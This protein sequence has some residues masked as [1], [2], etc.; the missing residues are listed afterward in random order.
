MNA[1]TEKFSLGLFSNCPTKLRLLRDC[2]LQIPQFDLCQKIICFSDAL[3][4]KK[5]WERG[6]L[7][8]TIQSDAQELFLDDWAKTQ[9]L[10]SPIS[11]ESLIS[12][13]IHLF[14]EEWISFKG[15]HL[16]LKEAVLFHSLEG[17]I[18]LSKKEAAL[19]H[20]LMTRSQAASRR[21]L[22]EKVWN[23]SEKIETQTLE[24]HLAKLRQKLII[25]KKLEIVLGPTGYFINHK[26][27][28]T[29]KM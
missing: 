8:A 29:D 20:C 17:R 9:K 28:I 21:L 10:P 6:H 7:F 12:W 25:F 23:Y 26:D 5:H 11:L 1:K 3:L 15:Y 14:D 16:N 18:L 27:S 4:L 22:L 2:L 24:S 19:M 13:C